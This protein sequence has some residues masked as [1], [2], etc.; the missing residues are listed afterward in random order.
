MK[1]R[2]KKETHFRSTHISAYPAWM[3]SHT[4]DPICLQVHCQASGDHVQ[5]TLIQSKCNSVSQLI[6]S[7]TCYYI[8]QYRK[9]RKPVFTVLIVQSDFV[10]H[11]SKKK[12]RIANS[13]QF[14]KQITSNYD[15]FSCNLKFVSCNSDFFKRNWEKKSHNCK[16]KFDNCLFFHCGNRLP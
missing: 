15:F 12:V 1:N 10:S 8:L 2:Y 6:Y 3:Q 7:Q 5:C 9:L 4:Q 14:S 16:I 13:K 11:N